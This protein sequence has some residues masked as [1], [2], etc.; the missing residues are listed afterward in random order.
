MRNQSSQYSVY[1]L[2]IHPEYELCEPNSQ[3]LITLPLNRSRGILQYQIE[4]I[5]ADQCWPKKVLLRR[6]KFATIHL[7][8][9]WFSS[10]HIVILPGFPSYI[11]YY[12]KKYYTKQVVL[13]TNF[14]PLI[15]SGVSYR[16]PWE[17]KNTVYHFQI[18]ALLL[19]IFKFEQSVKYANVCKWDNWWHHL[20]NPIL[21]Q[22][23]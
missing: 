13:W 5:L 9:I 18:S 20:L 4:W 1:D 21:Y 19:E 23:Y 3:Y 6:L 8:H 15:F 10:G 14:Y 2:H 11:K 7:N 17:N 12:I 22:V 16:I